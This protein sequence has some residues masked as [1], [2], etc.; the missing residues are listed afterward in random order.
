[1]ELLKRSRFLRKLAKIRTLSPAM[2][3][4]RLDDLAACTLDRYHFGKIYTRKDGLASRPRTYYFDV[5][6]LCN[7][8]CGMCYLRDVINRKVE[9]GALTNEEFL[10]IIDRDRIRRVNLIG[11]EPFLRKDLPELLEEF[12]R[13]GVL[14]DAFT[15]NGTLVT[16]ER[17]SQLARLVSLR[18]MS[19][20]TVSIDGPAPIHDRI[21]GK[22]AFDKAAEG[23][24]I[25]RDHL[26][27]VG[28][29]A[30]DHLVINSVI[31][32]ENHSEADSVA[33]IARQLGVKNI[34]LC[35]LMYTTPEDVEETNAI[36]G[37]RE[38]DIFQMHIA[39][40]PGINVAA[41]KESL[42]RFRRKVERYDIRA[43]IRPSVSEESIDQ[44][45]SPGY[46]PRLRCVQPFFITRV[47]AG[48]KVY[49]CTFIRKEMGDLREGP[50][51]EI[52]NSE[53]FVRHRRMMVERGVFPICKRCCKT[54][55]A[56]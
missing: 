13:R 23:L 46:A 32:A 39:S 16:E 56:P 20:I 12:E 5:T 14:C 9:G 50:L 8:R 25:L 41:L 36:L 55:P 40:E 6:N 37:N 29:D 44:I 10:H 22:G 33:D 28:G 3:R 21:R 35:H 17:A 47:G 42:H 54:Y 19:G 51:S 18:L 11:G 27:R 31:C 26:R 2:V 49:Y 48:G 7:L 38:P 24:Q 53:S 52:W 1:M 4:R 34:C 30:E 15:T 45:Y 43:V